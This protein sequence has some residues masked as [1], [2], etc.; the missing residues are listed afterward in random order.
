MITA[1]KNKQSEKLWFTAENLLKFDNALNHFI[2][3]PFVAAADF[4]YTDNFSFSFLMFATYTA[5]GQFKTLF[6]NK[7]D[8]SETTGS[9]GIFATISDVSGGYNFTYTQHDSGFK[10]LSPVTVFKYGILYA[11][12]I[13]HE[14]ATNT[15]KLYI[16]DMNSGAPIASAALGNT[17][18]I[19]TGLAYKIGSGGVSQ[20]KTWNGG[21]SSFRIFN[22]TLSEG[23][24]SEFFK[25]VLLIPSANVANCVVHVPLNQRFGRTA[26]EV[27]SGNHGVL[28]NYTDAET[29]ISGKNTAWINFFTKQPVNHAGIRGASGSGYINFGTALTA[30]LNGK[31]DLLYYFKFWMHAVTGSDFLFAHQVDQSVLNL[32]CNNANR[33]IINSRQGGAVINYRILNPDSTEYAPFAKL[34]IGVLHYKK[35]QVLPIWINGTKMNSNFKIDGNGTVVSNPTFSFDMNSGDPTQLLIF[36]DTSLIE[37]GV[38]HNTTL[39]DT[40]KLLLSSGKMEFPQTT[41]RLHHVQFNQRTGATVYDLSSNAK[42][43]TLIGMGASRILTDKS[44]F[45]EITNGVLLDATH[46]IS[47][48]LSGTVLKTLKGYGV[49][50]WHVKAGQVL[51]AAELIHLNKNGLFQNPTPTIKSKLDAYYLFNSIDTSS[52]NRILDL[53]GTNHATLTGSGFTVAALSSLY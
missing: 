9:K 4:D 52:G 39:S 15:A 37:Y 11:G 7:E 1:I 13:T 43:G 12:I 34:T 5:N 38:L 18:S 3:L 23:D 47:F 51:T 31:E 46:T 26:F 48:P 29:G 50:A 53:I 19:K 40:E 14:A 21:I 44:G 2:Q 32:R 42:N 35:G 36:S 16:K 41:E 6:S 49:Q 22:S 10:S 8:S 27:A 25:E 24:V 20:L 17:S 45:E 30:L 33:L 28:T